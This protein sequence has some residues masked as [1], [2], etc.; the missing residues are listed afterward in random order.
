MEKATGPKCE[1]CQGSGIAPDWKAIGAKMRE[2]RKAAN[3]TLL[4][5]A[6][7][8]GFSE[9]YI[10]DLEKGKRAFGPALQERYL[11]ALR[12]GN[13]GPLKPGSG[14]PSAGFAGHD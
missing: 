10:H 7:R 13:N 1:V 14:A 6:H 8:M 12:G 3:L 11:D 5:M 4:T 9:G 2:A